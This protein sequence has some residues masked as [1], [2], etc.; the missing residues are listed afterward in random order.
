MLWHVIPWQL[1]SWCFK[2]AVMCL[3]MTQTR[4]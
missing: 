4:R 3:L 2:K 1:A